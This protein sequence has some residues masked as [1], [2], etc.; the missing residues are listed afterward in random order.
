MTTRLSRETIL[1]LLFTTGFCAAAQPPEVVVVSSLPEAPIGVPTCCRPSSTTR[2][3]AGVGHSPAE[4]K[5]PQ[6]LMTVE[7]PSSQIPFLIPPPRAFRADAGILRHS[8]Q[9]LMV[10]QEGLHPPT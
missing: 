8:S 7:A 2:K 3:T 6:T 1:S 5:Q 4:M 9:A 10:G